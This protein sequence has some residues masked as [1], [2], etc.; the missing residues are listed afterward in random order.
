MN[1]KSNIGV[2]GHICVQWAKL[3]G[4]H[5]IGTCSS[6]EKVDFLKKLGCDRVIN[7]REENMDEVLTKEYPVCDIPCTY[8]CA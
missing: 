7:Y 5:V 6:K 3:K 8:S 2:L 1:Y 4:C